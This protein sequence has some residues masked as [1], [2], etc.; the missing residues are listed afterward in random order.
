MA[1][2]SR[3]YPA[4]PE[5]TKRLA[6]FLTDRDT[7]DALDCLRTAMRDA[8]INYRVHKSIDSPTRGAYGYEHAPDFP[9]RIAAARLILQAKF[10]LGQ[11]QEAPTTPGAGLPGDSFTRDD[12]L[13]G[14]AEMGADIGGI[15]SFWVS[16]IKKVG[17][18]PAKEFRRIVTEAREVAEF[19]DADELP[20]V[21][22]PRA[23]LVEPPSK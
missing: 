5:A 11:L 12:V 7:E 6:E 14:L 19:D 23:Q 21:I 15:A 3:P 2:S 20:Q 22:E 4:L 16:T 13:R 17:P 10:N 9:T 1:K 8:Y 18:V